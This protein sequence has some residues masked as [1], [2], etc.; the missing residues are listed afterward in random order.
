MI[1]SYLRIAVRSIFK[2]K[3]F[4]IINILGL[5]VGMTV[6]FLILHFAIFELSYDRF[7]ADLDN[8]VRLRGGAR[9]DSSAASAQAVTEAFP[10]VLNYVKLVRAGSWGIYSYGDKHFRMN[11]CFTAMNS[12]F[13]IFSFEI[14]KG[15]RSAPLSAINSMVLTESTA[16]KFFGDED[17][18]GQS[19]SYN[20][21]VDY[22]VTA[23]MR[24][25]P[26]NSHLRFDLLVSW[27]TIR[28][29]GE[30]VDNSWILWGFYSYL[31]IKPGTDL[32]D[33]QAKLDDFV[34]LKQEEVN[35]PESFWEEYHLQLLRDIHLYS[36]FVAE[37]S[38]NGSGGAVKILLLV[39]LLVIVIAWMNYVNLSTARSLERCREVGIRKVAGAG[40]TQLI[41]QFMTESLLINAAALGLAFIATYSW[42]PVFSTFTGTPE[43]FL[44]WQDARFWAG[45]AG[46][47]FCGVFLS[48][49]YPAVILASFSPVTVLR[50]NSTPRSRGRRLRKALVVFQFMISAGLIAATLTV[51][52]QVKFMKTSEL[53]LDIDKTLI[54]QRP[55]VI[56]DANREEFDSRVEAF[57]TELR[58]VPGVLDISRSSYVPGDDVGMI[59]EGRKADLPDDATIDVYEIQV[60]E[61]FFPMYKFK[62]LAGRPFSKEFPTDSSAVIMNDTARR[63]L[64]Y[65]TPESAVGTKFIYRTEFPY[66]VLGVLNDYH[67]ESLKQIFEPLVY[68]YNPGNNGLY[69]LKIN[70]PDPQ[71]LISRVKEIWDEFYPGNP[72]EYFFLDENYTRKYG[73]DVKFLNMFGIFALLAMSVAGLGLFGLSLFNAVQRTK[74][75]GIRK[76]VGATWRE[77]LVILVRDFIK[78][79]L[80][81]N[82][83]ALPLVFFAMNSWLNKYAFR[84]AIGVWFFIIPVLTTVVIAVLISAFHSIKAALSDP[85]EALRYE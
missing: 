79:I 14:V 70:T 75:I 17:P 69:S 23:V 84:T 19:L 30:M 43:N 28:Q 41:R 72:F 11:D 12:I 32:V 4:S 78:L 76:V 67:Q 83:V 65:P 53:G 24:D 85:V 20:G 1:R 64:G 54:L 73:S 47:L 52:R 60:D 31:R 38:E 39:A 35:R 29:R 44:L 55:L 62:F 8:I 58:R 42:L 5:T 51:S 21:R 61:T 81:A 22:E 56:R 63:Q 16:K 59:N 46:V 80:V 71:G 45:L 34:E 57:K 66:Q 6:C 10:E 25:V 2:R 33:L 27:P 37:A 50:E 82:V 18:V 26:P 15:D 7:H 40:R 13:E 74:E 48:G 49:L 77:I 36:S 9:A 3:A 68:L